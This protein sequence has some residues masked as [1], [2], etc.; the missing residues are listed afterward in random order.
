MLSDDYMQEDFP[1][2]LSPL[3][4]NLYLNVNFTQ[5]SPKK[6]VYKSITITSSILLYDKLVEAVP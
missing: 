4:C 2:M 5:A 6:T 1:K 3:N